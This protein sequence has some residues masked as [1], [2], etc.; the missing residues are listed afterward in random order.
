MASDDLL[1]EAESLRRGLEPGEKKKRRKAWLKIWMIGE[2][3][4]E[5]ELD[6]NEGNATE[7]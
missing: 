2:L 3:M 5:R 7:C 6:L 1:S 4:M